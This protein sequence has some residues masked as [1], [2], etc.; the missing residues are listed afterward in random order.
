MSGTGDPRGAAG[1]K[2]AK[3]C[4]EQDQIGK[5]LNAASIKFPGRSLKGISN[6]S[7]RGMITSP[8]FAIRKE[9]RQNPAYSKSNMITMRAAAKT[10]ALFFYVG[11]D[12]GKLI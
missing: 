1:V 2:T 9:G 5:R 3:L 10:A 12:D 6:D 8:F 11:S 4:A 7:L